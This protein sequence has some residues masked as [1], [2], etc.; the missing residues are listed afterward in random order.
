M[1]I[2]E[3]GRWYGLLS[4]FVRSLDG[5]D[6]VAMHNDWRLPGPVISEIFAELDA[7]FSAGQ[8]ISLSPQAGAFAAAANAR[9]MIDAYATHQQTAGVE[10]VLF[11]DGKPSEAI[12]HAEIAGEGD[13][14]QLLYKYIGS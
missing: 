7:F 11:A 14:M 10:C 12:L 6:E 9:P 1:D 5:R 2:S 13:A 8:T 3:Q 4:A